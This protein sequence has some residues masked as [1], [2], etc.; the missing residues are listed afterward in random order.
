M[1]SRFDTPAMKRTSDWILS[2]EFPSDITI[3]VRESTFNLHKLPLASRCGYIR[4]QVSGINGSKVTHLEIAGMPGGAKAFELVT[5]FCYGE[6]FEITEDNV[7]TLRCAAEHLEMTDECKTGNLIGRTE[8]YLEAVAL[9]SL[10]GAVTVLRK[11]EELLPVSEEVDIIGRCIDAIAYI[12]CSDSQFS[13]SLGTTAGSY[14]GV[15]GLSVLPPKA[16]DD[17]WADELTSLRIDT[18]QRVLIAMKA[19]GFKG[20]ALGTLI[21]LYAQKSLRRLDIHGRD[22]KKMDPRQEHEKRVVLETIVSLLPR[23]KNTMSVSFL[24]MLLRAALYLDTTLACLLDLEKR[25]AAQLGQAVLDDLLIPSSSPEAGTAFDVDA[26]QRILVGYLEHEGEAIWLDYSTEDDF[27]STASP[28]NDVGMVGK[29]MEAYLAEIASDV[30]LRIDKFIGLAEMIPERARF[31]EDGMYRAID[32]HLKAHPYLNEAERKKVCRVMDCQKLSRE[33]CAHAAQNDRLP[34]Q[35]VVQVLYHE[36][37]RLREASPY[38]TSGAPLSFGG[39]SPA[40]SYKPTPSLLGRHARSVPDEVARLQRENDEL[41]M[42]LLRLKMRMRDP[43]EFPEGS[44]I[45]PSGRAPLPKKAAA[46]GFMNNVSKKLGRLNP[47]VR[48]DAVGGGR[49]R[50]KPPKDRRHSIS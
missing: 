9:V 42:E 8:A 35:T 20:I 33:A 24:S 44:G 31:N 34:V 49:A 50:T 26:V 21:M 46:G 17:W 4:K 37:R 6:N 15:S 43:P 30:N 23:E 22:R 7:A 28:P 10:A 1:Q 40:I 12:T 25:M 27:I 47:F 36:Q 39:D 3:Q 2:Q 13:M 29:L 5:K 14:D 16:I 32:I 38:P 45:P 41:K 18:F 11:S 48:L 19:R